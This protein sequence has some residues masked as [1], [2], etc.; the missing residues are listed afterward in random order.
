MPVMAGLFV[1][2]FGNVGAGS[3]WHTSAIALNVGIING[4]TVM[5]IVMGFAHSLPLGVKV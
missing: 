1:D 2:E 4:F 3:F 5:V